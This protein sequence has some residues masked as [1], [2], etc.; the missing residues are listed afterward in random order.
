MYDLQY[1]RKRRRR[2]IAALVSLISAIGVTCLVIT[3]FL[4]RTVGT[5]TVAVSNSTVRLALS[6]TEEFKEPT[7]YLRIDKLLPLR[8]TSF[9][10]IKTRGFDTIDNEETEY[11]YAR[12]IDEDTKQPVALEFIKYTFYISNMSTT[13]AKYNLTINLGDR[14]KSSDGTER[15][16]DDTLRLMVFEND[17]TAGESHD[18]RV[19]AKESAEYNYDIKGNKTRREFISTYPSGSNQEDDEH[20]LAESFLPGQSVVKYSVGNFK[21]GDIRRYTLVMWLEG[22]DPQSD[23]SDEIPEGASLKLGVDIAAYENA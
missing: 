14:R 17:P 2:R 23:G 10:N 5:F 8:E 3:S 9:E 16:L 19:F 21:R 7:S 11:D 15:T 12:I 6:K 20:K 1:V 18:Y 22:E 4:G 13:I